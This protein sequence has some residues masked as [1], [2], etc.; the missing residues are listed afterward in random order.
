[1]SDGLSRYNGDEDDDDDDE[2]FDENL[3]SVLTSESL[4]TGPSGSQETRNHKYI[5][6]SSLLCVLCFK[7]NI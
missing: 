5:R 7:S 2:G 6:L 3:S 4:F 1:V